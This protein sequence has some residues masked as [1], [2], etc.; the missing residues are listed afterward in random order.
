MVVVVSKPR[1]RSRRWSSV[2]THDAAHEAAR[3]L[4][5]WV[6]CLHVLYTRCALRVPRRCG[7]VLACLP[8]PPPHNLPV[9]QTIR[10]MSTLDDTMDRGSSSDSD[11]SPSL[12]HSDRIERTPSAS[13]RFG[14]MSMFSTEGFGMPFGGAS[15]RRGGG[16]GGARDAK[17]RRREES[18][19]MNVGR[20]GGLSSSLQ[21]DRGEIGSAMRQKDELVDPQHVDTL[22]A[23]TSLVNSYHIHHKRSSICPSFQS[24][25]TPST[26]EC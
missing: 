19:G 25:A 17:S 16:G 9:S 12:F 1:R 4:S 18:F 26:T 13:S 23:R 21:F 2:V 20:R 5:A 22:R 6:Q 14:V 7:V 11:D 3:P 10:T 8:L 15:K 24:S